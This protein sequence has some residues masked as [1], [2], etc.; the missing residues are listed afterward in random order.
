LNDNQ[1]PVAQSEP[2]DLARLSILRG[3]RAGKR[4]QKRKKKKSSDGAKSA[5]GTTPIW[6]AAS[7]GRQADR[8]HHDFSIGF[9]L[10]FLERALSTKIKSSRGTLSTERNLAA[11]SFRFCAVDHSVS[12]LNERDS[13]TL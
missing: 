9:A 12:L 7:I 2:D 10:N 4:E 13:M 5:Q 8:Q 3:K 11:R 6:T 1:I